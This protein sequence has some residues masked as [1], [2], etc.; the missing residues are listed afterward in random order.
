MSAEKEKIL[1][2]GAGTMGHSLA[3]LFAKAGFKV[4]LVDREEAALKLAMELII[5]AAETLVEAGMAGKGDL[6]ALPDFINPSTNLENA[7]KDSLLAIETVDENPAAKKEVFSLLD[8]LCPEQTILASNTSALNIFKIVETRRPER[9]I[10]THFFA[11]PHIIPLVEV[12]PGPLTDPDVVSQVAG[13]MKKAG[14]EPLVL[15]EYVPGFLVNRIQRAIAREAFSLVDR[16]MASIEEVDRA[17][18]SSLGIRLPV[19]GVLQTYDFTGLDVYYKITKETPITAPLEASSPPEIVRRRVE[20]GSFGVKTG[21][22]LYDYGGR[23]PADVMRKR[24]LRYMEVLKALG[25]D[26]SPL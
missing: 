10:I 16:G 26:N 5:S 14:K 7:C 6:K 15:K 24:D 12:V 17:V 18:R 25:R 13:I 2:V 3:L 9:V 8:A 23:K 1:I 19:V 21:K 20:E 11:P 4:A 22:G